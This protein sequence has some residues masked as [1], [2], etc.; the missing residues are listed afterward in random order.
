MR[1]AKLYDRR[2]FLAYCSLT[3][4]GLLVGCRPQ[5]L[6]PGLDAFIQAKMERSHIP[7]LAAAVI[8]NRDVVWSKG[9]GWA[10]I[11]RRV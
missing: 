5:E 3:A 1:T 4:G 6:Q 7:G 11:D 2:D 8:K 9:Y 10:D